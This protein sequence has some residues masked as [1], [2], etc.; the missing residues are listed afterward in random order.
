[1]DDSTKE[2]LTFAKTDSIDNALPP[3]PSLPAEEI[4]KTIAFTTSSKP[5]AIQINDHE[6]ASTNQP[7]PIPPLSPPQLL[8][9]LMVKPGDTLTVLTRQV[10]GTR[11]SRFLRA[12]IAANANIQNPDNIDIGNTIAFPSIARYPAIPK[13]PFF[14][15]VLAEYPSLPAA[16]EQLQKIGP[17]PD[18]NP[19]M[20]AIWSPDHQLRFQIILSKVFSSRQ[21]AQ[22]SVDKLPFAIA[23]RSMILTGWP[24]NTVFYSDPFNDKFR[25]SFKGEG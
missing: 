24:E 1:M 22:T 9:Q 5:A 18:S 25:F 2:P 13:T 14:I 7:A 6:N 3:A 10:Y 11:Q 15:V 8:G 17:I 20:V 23:T 4:G 12:V 19:K 16:I 21:A